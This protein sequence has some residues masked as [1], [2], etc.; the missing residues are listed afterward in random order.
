MLDSASATGIFV[1]QLLLL[2]AVGRL[3]GEAMQRIGQPPVMG[4]LLG[5]VL[6]GP[7]VLGLFVPHLQQQLFPPD[8]G[9]RGMLEGVAQ[10]GIL[11]LLV[12]TGMDM[13][14][15]RVLRARRAALATSVC[16]IVVPFVLGFGVGMLLPEHILPAANRRLITALFLGIALSIS[17]VKIVA[18]VIR[19]LDFTRRRVGQ[20]IVAAA[21][22]DDTLGW[23]I[24]SLIMGIART[25]SVSFSGLGETALATGLFLLVTLTVGRRAVYFLLR[26]SNDHLVS[27]MAVLTTT[28][29][30]MGVLALATQAAGVQTVLGAFVAGMLI[31]QSPILTR[32]I[33]EQLRGMVVALFMPVFFGL[34]GLGADLRVIAEPR[35]LAI[36]LAFIGIASLGKFLGAWLGGA[37]GGLTRAESL[38]LACG[39]NARGSTEVIIASLGLALGALDTTLFTLI[40][41]M[42][43]ATTLLMPP[44]LRRALARIPVSETEQQE[45]ERA[46]YESRDFVGRLE[47][48]LLVADDSASGRLAS[49]LI[50]LI[51]AP[52]GIPITALAPEAGEGRGAAEGAAEQRSVMEAAARLSQAVTAEESAGAPP[53]DLIE[54]T[55]PERPEEAIAAEARKGY[56]LLTIGMEPLTSAGNELS[57]E[58]VRAAEGFER[59]ICVIHAR[60]R[61]LRD[62]AGAVHR[63]LLPVVGASYARAAADLALALAQASGASLTAL[64]VPTDA[65]RNSLRRRL[66]HTWHLG[67][68]A[69][70]VLQD[71]IELS[72]HYSVPVRTALDW[73]TAASDAIAREL[74]RSDYDLIV[75]GLGTRPGDAAFL[76]S[77]SATLVERSPCS[78][79]LLST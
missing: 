71:V 42:A 36:T 3:L 38:A 49:Y 8:A 53:L 57:P 64:Y 46:E 12:I 72:R 76:G 16:G 34:A 7:S 2:L 79:I 20:I 51:A 35:L 59:A 39:L 75:L 9:H 18:S 67:D 47:R 50:A 74:A 1:A 24:L 45:L 48:L 21:I 44:M 55:S 40:V 30:V 28:V 56:D 62:P 32:H 17:S 19:D 31:G 6:L 65:E 43:V 10:L 14:F 52:R 54:R 61:H 5:G 78:L 15:G 73:G 25:G 4:Q 70:T 37:I 13:D 60:G 58:L 29:I 27:E 22:V 33:S 23:L 26:W 11:M 69:E 77:A 63:V 41:T 68:A 66:Q